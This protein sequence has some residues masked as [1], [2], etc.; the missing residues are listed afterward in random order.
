M[1]SAIRFTF[2][3][4]AM[5]W[6]SA[7]HAQRSCV[8]WEPGESP[9]ITANRPPAQ[10]RRLFR[11][12]PIESLSLTNSAPDFPN[13][14]VTKDFTADQDEPSISIEPGHP[15]FLV[16]GANDFRSQNVL[17]SYNS[18]DGGL[19]WH[20]Q[21]LP[22][23]ETLETATDPAVAF[24]NSDTVYF[25]NGILNN[26]GFPAPKNA[27]VCYRSI[28]R[29]A[30]WQTPTT[31]FADLS[32]TPAVLADKYY[33]AV[34][35][36]PGSPH[37][38]RIYVTW[39]EIAN[40][41]TRIVE[42]FS[43]DHGTTWSP[44]VYV[45][46]D[47]RQYQCPIPAVLSNGKLVVTY[48]DLDAN[49]KQILSAVSDGGASFSA[50]VKVADYNNLGPI[51]PPNDINGHPAI[52]DSLDVNSFPSIAVDH[53]GS[54]RD[55]IYIAYVSRENSGA[56]HVFLCTSDN[57]GATWSAPIAID[58]DTGAKLTDK[59]FSWITVDQ[60]QG[61]VGVCFYDSRNDPDSNRLCDIYLS[62]SNDGGTNFTSRRVTSVSF[63]P[64]FSTEPTVQPLRF[65]GDYINIAADSKQWFPVWTDTRSGYDQDIYTA[66]VR[67]YSPA[68]VSPFAAK[69]ITPKVAELNWQY[70]AKSTFGF[71]IGGFHFLLTRT[72]G[73]LSKSLSSLTFTV[74][75]S[76]VN[77]GAIYSYTIQVIADNGDTSMRATALYSP[78]EAHTPQPPQ[79]TFAS[80]L[81]T[82]TYI[83]YQVPDKNILGLP[84][85]GLTMMYIFADGV[86]IDSTQTSDAE[87][88]TVRH[89]DLSLSTGYHK[90]QLQITSTSVDSTIHS[91][92][93]EPK[94][95]YAGPAITSYISDFS[96]GRNVFSPFGWDTT[97]AN[98]KFTT[99]LLNDSLPFVNYRAGADSWFLL[100]SLTISTRHNTLEIEDIGLIA[101]GDSGLIEAS[102]DDGLTFSS[103]GMVDLASH[104]ALWKSTLQ[105][106]DTAHDAFA[107]KRFNGSNLVLRFRLVTHSSS[108]DGWF[109]ASIKTSDLLVVAQTRGDAVIV[110]EPV[111]NPAHVGSEVTLA[112]T[113]PQPGNL[114]VY[115][116]NVL[117][118]RREAL[119][120][121]PIGSGR[122]ELRVL[123]PSAGVYWLVIELRDGSGRMTQ[124]ARKSVVLP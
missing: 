83:V 29:G 43:S 84:I 68:S 104:P 37:F 49:R 65:F 1:R 74:R 14:N 122:F 82:G 9:T 71:P 50:S 36:D 64:L 15:Q 56:D 48:I 59:F 95:L 87:R 102:T 109:I 91:S 69:E 70:L 94:Y 58:G 100:P 89:D 2:L 44:R 90:I 75:D 20:S 47:R 80:N 76:S 67:P 17:W 21:P 118:E 105:T 3:F 40:G 117:G 63:D 60:T 31:V 111:P 51:K 53:S 12:P 52:K 86:L 62:L 18:T 16:V 22:V 73:G 46:P 88:G 11:K 66:L 107:L 42:A 28:D 72:D 24:T 99:P 124:S 92:L 32:T 19:H 10:L 8:F 98:G 57:S 114:K 5:L 113:S 103:V 77:P 116:V 78:I 115:L 106:S 25:T 110:S 4:I 39:T 45:T 34:D 119:N 35:N 81:V 123:T 85:A 41:T 101:P 93:S 54:H 38:G 30:T 120:S 7:S 13:I 79:L 33:S 61:D 112:I 121:T 96:H 27:V 6:Y 26:F 23:A 108:Q 97:N 55:R